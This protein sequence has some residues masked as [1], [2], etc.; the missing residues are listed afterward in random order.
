MCPPAAIAIATLAINAGGAVMQYMQQKQQAKAQEQAN[1]AA[2]LSAI[3]SANAQTKALHTRE[4]QE[5]EAALQKKDQNDKAA[6]RAT[7]TS[8]TAAGEAGV[9]GLSLD[10][11]LFNVGFQRGQNES[12]IDFNLDN[13]SDQLFYQKQG[14]QAQ[15]AGRI[16]S[17]PIVQRPSLF[18]TGLQIA[19]AG[20]NAFKTFQTASV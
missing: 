20:V 13:T 17:L 5:R 6:R 14:V 10:S 7:A 1:A 11:L 8:V 16:A 18:A 12:N 15:S 3:Q 2:R 19:G 4:I 9:T